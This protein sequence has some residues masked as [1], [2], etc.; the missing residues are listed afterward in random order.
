MK[1]GETTNL[2][3]LLEEIQCAEHLLSIGSVME[4]T[5]LK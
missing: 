3:N 5:D 1:I 2:R 4:I